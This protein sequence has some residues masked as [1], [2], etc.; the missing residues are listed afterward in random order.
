[1]LAGRLAGAR[2][3]EGRKAELPAIWETQATAACSMGHLPPEGLKAPGSPAASAH[4]VPP[5]QAFTRPQGWPSP[6]LTA[7]LTAKPS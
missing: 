5:V 4:M 7:V 2:Q 6:A 1:M 3:G